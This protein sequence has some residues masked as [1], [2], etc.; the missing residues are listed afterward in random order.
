MLTRE[1]EIEIET[2]AVDTLRD[3][4][5]TRYPISIQEVAETLGIKLVPYSSLS[6]ADG[7]LARAASDDAFHARTW[8]FSKASIVFDDTNKAYYYRSRFSGGHE[9]GHILL[10]HRED[11]PNREREADYFS[12]YLLAPHPLVL[13]CGPNC[14]L[15]ATFKVSDAC[16]AC[17]LDQARWRKD[18]GKARYPHEEWLV[19]NVTGREGGPVANT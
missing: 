15:S 19:S 3:F 18:E 9:L 17:A 2:I 10:E 5:L 6:A 14:N 8:D 1:R 11:T 12:G 7:K 4:G 13:K 16:A